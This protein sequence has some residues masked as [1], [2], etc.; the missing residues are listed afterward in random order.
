MNAGAMKKLTIGLLSMA[1]LGV[2][3]LRGMAA[4]QTPVT[5]IAYDQ[6]R[7]G[8]GWGVSCSIGMAVD[9]SDT[10]IANG[11]DPK[12]SPDGTRIAFTG[13]AD[14]SD[15][16]S[17]WDSI[18][19]VLVLNLA[20]SSITTLTDPGAGW[21]PVWSPDGA[22][23]AFL[24]YR[25]G[26]LELYVMEASGA[27]P[28]RVTHDVGFT[29]T[30]VWS[31]DG[32]RLA[33]A[34]EQDGEPELYATDVDGSNVVRLTNSVGFTGSFAWSPDGSRI[35]FDCLGDGGTDICTVNGDGTNFVLLVGGPANDSG[36]AFSPVDGRIAFATTRFGSGAE[37]AVMDA[38]GVVTRVA[39]GTGGART[40]RGRPTVSG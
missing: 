1:F 32:R 2:P 20:D 6:C 26:A 19:Q 15:P 4:A 29:G 10:L 16:Y 31:P 14:P 17:P 22:K 28:T 9:G 7:A 25:D 39:A 34:S 11:V 36:A 12:W 35:A 3:G 23:I 18:P 8:G 5:R 27:N 21:G 13:S 24:S 40:L 33:F 37:I 30:F 38:D